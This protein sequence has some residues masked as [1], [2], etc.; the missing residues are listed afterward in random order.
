M[1]VFWTLGNS[2]K[3]WSWWIGTLNP[4]FQP[5]VTRIPQSGISGAIQRSA[6]TA[7]S[8][9]M[10]RSFLWLQIPSGWTSFDPHSGCT[11]LRLLWDQDKLSSLRHQGVPLT[12]KTPELGLLPRGSRSPILG[13]ESTARELS[14][15]S[16]APQQ[17]E[18]RGGRGLPAVCAHFFDLCAIITTHV[19]F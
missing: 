6:Q 17:P 16:G 10:V 12:V 11:S 14:S 5:F 8:S 1:M 19:Y 7:S 3:A 13:S 4:W 15:V 2:A 9:W 18:R